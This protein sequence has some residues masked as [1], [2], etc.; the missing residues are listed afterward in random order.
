METPMFSSKENKIGL[1]QMQIE[2]PQQIMVL[3]CSTSSN[4]KTKVPLH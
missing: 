1:N 3:E 2:V 4:K